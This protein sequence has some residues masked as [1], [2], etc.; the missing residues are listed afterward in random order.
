MWILCGYNW[1]RFVHPDDR[2][3]YVNNFFKSVAEKGIFDAQFRLRRYDGE[4]RWMRSIAAPRFTSQGEFLGYVGSTTDITNIK[5]L[6]EELKEAQTNLEEKIE[7]LERSN[8]ELQQFAYVVSHDLQEPLRTISSFTELLDRR[9]KG[10]LDE[11]AN[12]FMEYIVDAAVRMK[13]QIEG[14]LE[15]SRVATKGEEFEPV[16]TNKGLNQTIKTLIPQLTNLMLK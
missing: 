13:E 3:A 12:E 10:K 8:D 16:N 5:Q 9:Y 4:Y 14:L 1:D 7:E 15:F 6:E 11:N 2:E